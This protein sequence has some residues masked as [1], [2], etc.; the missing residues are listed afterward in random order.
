[1][2]FEILK[3]R[4]MNKIIRLVL[5]ALVILGIGSC[6]ANRNMG[7]SSASV[8]QLSGNVN[9]PDGALVYALPL[10]V[11]D[12]AIETERVI[13]KPGP[14][15]AYAADLLGL[16]DVI[17]SENEYWSVTGVTISTH[18]EIDPDGYFAI[19]APGVF[20][21]N[22]L[23]MKKAGLILDLNPEMYD[24]ENQRKNSL[25][26]G[27]EIHQFYDMGSDEYFRNR[28]DT[29]YRV[30]SV[31][32]AFV[33]IPYLVVKKQ[34]LNLDQLAERAAIRLMELRDGKHLLLTGET[35]LFPQDGSA[36]AEINRLERQYTE[37]FAGK[38]F[39]EKRTF[40]YQITPR[41][42]QTGRKIDL[43]V[44]SEATG[45]G[46]PGS[47]T[48]DPVTIEFT[49]EQKTRN[50]A[51]PVSKGG[52]A[53]QKYSRIVCRLPDVAEVKLSIG[54]TVAGSGRKLIYQFG[55][56]IQMPSNYL[57]GK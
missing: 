12:I 50:I 24:V 19:S 1:L 42:D 29:L 22:V 15:S 25:S 10:T 20:R 49:P 38:V 28:R 14:Y 48:G 57:I 17:K 39:S 41:K 40:R 6:A 9:V 55:E 26:S 43:C 45:P 30:V 32:T 53:Q 46:D 31:D 21:T 33:R 54:N 7:G 34:K 4:G 27:V 44:F 13:E 23:E 37:L 16:T 5:L 3:K 51:S 52:P 11:V 2:I 56:I 47:K 36:I 35:N 18:E 8:S